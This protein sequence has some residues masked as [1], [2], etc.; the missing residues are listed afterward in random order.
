VAV[1]E[2]EAVLVGVEVLV[3]RGVLVRV[4]VDVEVAVA[5]AVPVGTTCASLTMSGSVRKLTTINSP[6]T[7]TNASCL[8]T[9]RQSA[10]AGAACL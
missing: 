8:S 4:G 6:R 2:A 9:G 10:I 1:G 5:V 3:C 7:P